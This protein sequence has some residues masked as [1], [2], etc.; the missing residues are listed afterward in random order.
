MQALSAMNGMILKCLLV[1]IGFV[2][3]LNLQ[4]VQGQSDH[5]GDFN[6][7]P[8][9]GTAAFSYHLENG[10]TVIQGPFEMEYVDLNRPEGKDGYFSLKGNFAKNIPVGPWVFEFGQLEPNGE[11]SLKNYHYE[12][13]LDGLL[14][15]VSGELSEGQ[16]QGPWIHEVQEIHNSQP[17]PS[18]FRSEVQFEAGIPQ[19][20]LKIESQDTVLLGRFLRNGLAHDV[21]TLF[22][23]QEQSEHWHFDEGRLEK[24]V[25]KEG[26]VGSLQL[27]EFQE[28]H[29]IINLDGRYLAWLDV[30]LKISGLE[31]S[32]VN[33]AAADLILRNSQYYVKVQ[34]LLQSRKNYETP[35]PFQ[36]VVPYLPLTSDQRRRVGEIRGNLLEIDTLHQ[37]LISN[38]SINIAKV[39]DEE[40]SYWQALI[41][42]LST[43]YMRPMRNLIEYDDQQI[44]DYLPKE[45]LWEYLWPDLPASTKLNVRYEMLGSK[46]EAPYEVTIPE[47]LE[48]E[49]DP[50]L[51]LAQVTRVVLT[52]I[53]SIKALIHSKVGS[54]GGSEQL[55]EV[56]EK[57]VD[58][59][60]TLTG[61]LDSAQVIGPA[62]H[63]LN[64]VQKQAQKELAKYSSLV[65]INARSI[66]ASS[67]LT[68]MTTLEELA[69]QITLLPVRWELIQV[70][71][72]DKVWNNFTSTVMSEEV[73]KRITQSYRDVLV[74]HF[75]QLV[76]NDLSCVN[77]NQ[78]VH[79]FRQSY[80][81]MYELRHQDTAKLERKLRNEADPESVMELMGMDLANLEKS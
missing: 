28:P 49:V 56:E 31:H 35:V 53:D 19:L 18:R 70:E 25:L 22:A 15:R 12:M 71:Y 38:S 44:L 5:I 24:I 72:T 75:L 52:Q 50:T 65:D 67:T 80:E 59:V 61:I 58:K 11:I 9:R 57:L 6:L 17:G 8:L 1:S 64:E 30:M 60:R 32:M 33:G 55:A 68:C 81:R 23:N 16:Y 2:S 43:E 73:K 40:I 37:A 51:A 20:A 27:P 79:A 54:L 14:H 77:A 26:T 42:T 74:P 21:W 48:K 66:Q 3:M 63:A 69:H 62:S 13:S 7:G 76:K 10:D 34:D 29:R 46:I 4:M 41:A 47:P 39:T 45:L 78:L 36:I